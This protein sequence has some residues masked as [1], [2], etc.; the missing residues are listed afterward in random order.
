MDPMV[1]FGMKIHKII[2]HR[3]SFA[4]CI[5][6]SFR[7]TSFSCKKAFPQ[8]V[9]LLRSSSVTQSR[10][11]IIKSQKNQT[12]SNATEY[13]AAAWVAR[14]GG[15]NLPQSGNPGCVLLAV[16]FSFHSRVE[17]HQED[18][19]SLLQPRNDESYTT[20]NDLNLRGTST[21]GVDGKRLDACLGC[22]FL[23]ACLLFSGQS[24]Q[25]L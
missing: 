12:I 20:H 8:N 2:I 15:G 14:L 7:R 3:D 13:S 25:I 21:N 1:F 9:S 24:R 19:P 6:Q 11:Q 5:P 10:N 18:P 17:R 4:P 22:A 16:R 23:S